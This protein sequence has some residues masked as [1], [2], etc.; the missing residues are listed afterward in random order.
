MAIAING[1]SNVIT[2]L[3][4]GGL[5]DGSVDA[6]TLASNA[7]TAGKLAS[8]VGGKF[9]HYESIIWTA[10]TTISAVSSRPEISSSLRFTYTPTSATNKII[11]RYNIRMSSYNPVTMFFVGK[12]VS[13]YSDMQNSEYVTQ[14]ATLV[15]PSYTGGDGGNAAN[16]GGNSANGEM[17]QIALMA[18][19]T[20]G[21]TNQRIYSVH[22]KVTSS[23][24]H[25]NRWTGASY[26]GT[27]FA[28]LFEVTP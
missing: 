5:P 24:V 11:L 7:V 14:P 9:V 2:G 18:I 16:Y 27:S 25:F 20:A 10:H 1:S 6:D 22:C 15:A 19:E 23:T 28:E 26:Y 12:D 3:S 4:V 13:N 17:R 21:N 8:G